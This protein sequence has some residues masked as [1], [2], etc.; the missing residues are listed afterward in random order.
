MYE[1]R[2]ADSLQLAAALTW[3]QQR[4]ATVSTLPNTS[5]AA[6]SVCSVVFT[7][8]LPTNVVHYVSH[9][10]RAEAISRGHQ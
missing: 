2:A 4:P 6:L 7:A 3:C 9:V 1:L 10:C 5:N 8:R